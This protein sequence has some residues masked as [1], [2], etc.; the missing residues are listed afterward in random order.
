MFLLDSKPTQMEYDKFFS[1]LNERL[2]LKKA[3]YL[4]L[5]PQTD[6]DDLAQFKNASRLSP[7]K[8]RHTYATRLFAATGNLRVVQEQ[9][10]HQ[11]VSTTEIYADV[12]LENRKSN[13]VKLKYQL[14]WNCCG[15]ATM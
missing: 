6:K 12:E 10:G 1:V 4:K 15:F 11:Q 7:H 13:V 5:H 8:C 2:D 9:L 14:L 3:E